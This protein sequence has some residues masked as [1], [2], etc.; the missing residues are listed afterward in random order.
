LA[1]RSYEGFDATNDT[2][3]YLMLFVRISKNLPNNAFEQLCDREGL[4]FI[5]VA[6]KD[7]KQMWN[8]T[9]VYL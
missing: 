3:N 1:L 2:I 4:E 9:K 8:V 7:N 5:F 6:C